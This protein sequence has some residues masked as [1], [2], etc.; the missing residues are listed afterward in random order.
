MRQTT[1]KPYEVPYWNYQGDELK[2]DPSIPPERL[3]TSAINP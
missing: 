3:S 2:P 1:T